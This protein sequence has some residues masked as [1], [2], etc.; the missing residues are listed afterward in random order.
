[1]TTDKEVFEIGRQNLAA[2]RPQRTVYLAAEDVDRGRC[3]RGGDG[4]CQA[5]DADFIEMCPRRV[6]ALERDLVDARNVS[7]LKDQD[8]LR[9]CDKVEAL[10]REHA[11]LRE[12]LTEVMDQGQK[13][14][15][16]W[17]AAERENARLRQESAERLAVIIA[18]Q[19]LGQRVAHLRTLL[20]SLHAEHPCHGTC[21]ICEALR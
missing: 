10:E 14:F 21:P 1:M 6:E 13:N 20:D 5:H 7:Y 3:L 12:Q 18:H 4:R 9:L 17:K 2:N 8:R 19:D 15:A 11:R 16:A